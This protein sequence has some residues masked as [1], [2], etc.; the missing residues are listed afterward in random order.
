[1]PLDLSPFHDVVIVTRV[2]LDGAAIVGQGVLVQ[3]KLTSYVWQCRAG[4]STR[5]RP[6]STVLT[7]DSRSRRPSLIRG[8]AKSRQ[9]L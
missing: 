4:N 1:M 7:P 9:P 2:E 8:T 6:P 3:Q 5:R